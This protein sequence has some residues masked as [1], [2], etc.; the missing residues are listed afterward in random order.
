[1]PTDMRSRIREEFGAN[2]QLPPPFRLHT[3]REAGRAF[4]HAKAIAAKEG[5]GALVW[6]GR[7]DLVEFALVLEPDEPLAAARRTIYAGMNALADTL[8]VHAPPNT[9]IHFEWPDALFVGGGLVGGGQL[10]WPKSAAENKRPDW[11]VFGAVVR[12]AMNLVEPGIKPH[13]TALEEEGFD[14]LGPG[15]V[16]ETFARHF[17]VAIDAWQEEGFNLAAEAY[18]RRLSG[19]EGTERSIDGMG[20]LLVRKPGGAAAAKKKLAPALVKPSW[21]DPES[22]EI[23]S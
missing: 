8:A 16:V 11:I 20:D 21:I 14:E 10:A 4:E 22:G 9:L 6:V 17:M 23:L 1:M 2:L 7:F 13:L 3:L 12:T 15:R 19:G 18:L 5:A